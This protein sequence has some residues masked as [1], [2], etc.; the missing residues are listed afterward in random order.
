MRPR[1]VVALALTGALLTPAAGLANS[2]GAAPPDLTTKQCRTAW[3][4][5][6]AFH[7]E[8]GNPRGPV[9]PLTKRWSTRYLKAGRFG[10]HAGAA[11]CDARIQRFGRQWNRL[12]S[13]Q[14]DLQEV[15]PRAQLARAEADRL[16]ALERD[17][18]SKLSPELEAEF[19]IARREAPPAIADLA[20]VLAKAP[21]VDLDDKPALR[22]YRHAVATVAATS[23]H[24]VEFD[25]AIGVISD[26]E[27]HE[28]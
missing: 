14:Y 23:P 3:V 4:D 7:G 26:A 5:L 27:L 11:S 15:D 10:R 9:P 28:E 8:N 17:D 25:R 20:G 2:A 18:T 24:V 6:R 1:L 13:F 22:D 21:A 19:A 16:H 12:E